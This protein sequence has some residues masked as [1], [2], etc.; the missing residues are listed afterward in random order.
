MFP[1]HEYKTT[2]NKYLDIL[3]LKR[4]IFS[5]LC[6]CVLPPP[7]ACVPLMRTLL[8]VLLLSS[9]YLKILRDQN[10]QMEG[11][12]IVRSSLF[13]VLLQFTSRWMDKWRVVY[14]DQRTGASHTVFKSKQ[15]FSAFSHLFSPANGKRRSARKRWK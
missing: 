15:F 14:F 2:I 6:H 10:D 1:T 5:I 13:V 8:L 11:P 3:R 12:K 7:R 9:F 4:N